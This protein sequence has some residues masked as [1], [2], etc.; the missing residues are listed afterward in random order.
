MKSEIEGHEAADRLIRLKLFYSGGLPEKRQIFVTPGLLSL[1]HGPWISQPKWPKRKQWE[2]RWNKARQ[3]LDDFI[4]GLMTDRI[5]VRSGP[6]KKSSCFMSRLDPETEEIWEI[7]VRDP[8]PGLRILGSFARQDMFVALTAAPHECLS[9]EEDWNR[10]IQQYKKKRNQY[11]TASP[12]S[13]SYPHDY[14]TNA[15]ILD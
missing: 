4:D 5:Y 12:F 15:F 7:R 6:R 9:T 1:L 8:K 3:H 13:G 2:T 14:I 11:F 10:V